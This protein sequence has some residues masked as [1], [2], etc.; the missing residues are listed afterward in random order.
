VD[1]KGTLP[2]I[3]HEVKVVAILKPNKT[4]D[5]PKNYKPHLIAFGNLQSI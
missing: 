1:T 4:G 2:K 3:W 5:D